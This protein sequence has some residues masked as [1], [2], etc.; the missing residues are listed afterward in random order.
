MKKLHYLTL[1]FSL[2]LFITAC[3]DDDDSSPI[4]SDDDKSIIQ[5]AQDDPT[6]SSF[7]AAITRVDLG[8]KFNEVGID[9]FTVLAPTNDAFEALL[10][11]NP[12]WNTLDDIPEETLEAVLNYHVI[13]GEYESEDLTNGWLTTWAKGPDDRGQSIL[14]NVENGVMFDEATVQTADIDAEEGVIHKI[15]TVLLPK[16]LLERALA[17]DEFSILVDAVQTEGLTVDFVGALKGDGNLTLFA[18]TNAAFLALLEDNAEWNSLEDIDVSLLNDVLSYHVTTGNF[19]S[20]KLSDGLALP[21]LLEGKAL[22]FNAPTTSLS[23][24]SGQDV[25]ITY[26]NIQTSNGVIHVIEE[27]LLP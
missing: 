16:N 17:L 20:D 2:G 25:S 18:P 23:T 7:V 26:T 22:R 12:E 1:L 5:I 8:T 27:V 15:N 14:V 21:T 10:N 3:D 4:T 9:E 6:L 11:S 13:P 24:L 19:T